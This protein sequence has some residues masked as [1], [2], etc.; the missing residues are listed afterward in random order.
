MK[1]LSLIS[2]KNLSLLVNGLEVNFETKK[3]MNKQIYKLQKQGF[4][5]N[6]FDYSKT[7]EFEG[8]VHASKLGFKTFECTIL[9]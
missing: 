6:S 8:L 2:G 3:E 5:F 9:G 4:S 7:D 1:T